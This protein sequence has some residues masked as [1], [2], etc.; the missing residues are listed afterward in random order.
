MRFEKLLQ[1]ISKK[2]TFPIIRDIFQFRLESILADPSKRDEKT[3][4]NLLDTKRFTLSG[5][6]IIQYMV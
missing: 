5:F 4:D 3:Q 6:H 2:F 1:L